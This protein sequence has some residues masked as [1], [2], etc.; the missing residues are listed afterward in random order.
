MI[1]TKED[2]LYHETNNTCHFC[3]KTCINKERD[4]CHETGKY[5]GPAC[6]I[7]NLRYKQQ[8]FIPVIFHNGSGYDFNLLYSE[9]FKQNNDKRKVDNI[10]LAAGKSKMFS[11]GCLKFLDSYNFLAMPLD[12]MAKIYGCETKT[13]Y[14]YEYFGLESNQYQEVKG[15]LKIEDFKSS[16]HNKLPTQE[17]VDNFN[18]ENSHKTGKYLTIEYLQNDVEIL[19]YCMNE[20][21]TLS[22]KE[23]K[24]NPLHYVSLPGYSF[25]CWLMSSGVTL[26]TLQH[27]QMLDDF[28]GAKRGGIC[29]IMGDRYINI[30][31]TNNNA[32]INDTNTNTNTNDKVINRNIWYIDAN[33]LYGYAM[34]QKLPNKD[35]EFITT[36]TLDIILNTPDDSDHGYYIVCD[37]DYTYECTERTEQLALMPNKRKINDNEL[38]YRQREKSKARSEK[39]ILDQNNKTEYMVHYRMLKF[40]VKMGVKVT[41]IHRVIKFK[42]DYICS[43]YIQNNTNKRATAK[44]EAEK[45]VRKL[46]NNSLYERMSMNPLHLFQSKFLH[47]EEKIMKSVSKPT[48]KNI[49]RY[50]DYSQI[51]Y[52]KKKIEYDSPVYVGVTILELSKLHMYDVFYNILQPSLKDLTLHYMDTDSFVLSYSEGKVSDEHMDLSN[53]D[54][55][56]K[57]NNKVPGKFKHELGSRIIDEFIV[58]SPKTYSF[59]DYPKNTKEK[60]IKKHNNARHIDYYDVLMNNT[61]RTVDEC[62]IQKV[63]DNMTTTK[64]SRISLNTFDDK[65]LCK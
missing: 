25:D 51:E 55:P 34:M 12:Q 46:M 32:N 54:I 2:K 49:T 7:C 9:L 44:T 16:L 47:D 36:T 18:N 45:D 33:N 63:G 59:K 13:L 6:K 22:M 20:Y 17:E 62:R 52:I 50:R 30:S 4:H 53:L 60:G 38:G 35:F 43:D 11:I 42:Q 29:G 21:V 37:I 31:N 41:K 28:V 14:P 26:D 64:T 61:Q 57:T 15:N 19:D 24:L 23:F 3:S 8:N 56:I 1:F 65:I 48:F 58:L 27:K 39:L 10:P 5:R 40:Y